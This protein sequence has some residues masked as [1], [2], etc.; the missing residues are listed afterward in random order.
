MALKIWWIPKLI[1]Y[2]LSWTWNMSSRKEYRG[3]C[4]QKVKCPWVMVEDWPLCP[5]WVCVNNVNAPSLC[6]QIEC[7]NLLYQCSG[8]CKF[9][10]NVNM[11]ETQIWLPICFESTYNYHLRT[12]TCRR[13]SKNKVLGIFVKMRNH[14][15]LSLGEM[16]KMAMEFGEIWRKKKMLTRENGKQFMFRE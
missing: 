14:S 13:R 11:D 7:W 4:N 12:W 16:T 3:I 8:I 9:Y 1:P 6:L 10:G 5:E 15:L 2:S